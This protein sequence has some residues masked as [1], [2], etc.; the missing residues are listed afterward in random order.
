[1]E[2]IPDF[3]IYSHNLL[4]VLLFWGFAFIQFFWIFFFYIR[5]VNHKDRKNT[6]E[7]VP[8]SIIIVARNEE[9]NLFELLPS[10]LMQ[11][12]KDFEVIVVNHQSIDNTASILKAYKEKYPR[13][14][15]IN[16]ERNNHLGYGKKLPLTVGIKGAKH[17]HILLTDADCKPASSQ[18]LKIMANQFTKQKKIVLGYAP[19][20]KTQSFLNRIIRIDTTFTALNYLSFA[21]VG[22][23][24]M[25]SGKNLGYTKDLFFKNR[26]F[27]SHY[28]IPA[29]DDDLFIQEIAKKN[30]KNYTISLS[31]KA[32]CY[33]K[34]KNRWSSWISDKAINHATYS[35]YTLF[36][37][38]LLGIYPTSLILLYISLLTL[39]INNWMCWTSIII[40][41]M[42]LISKWLV[43]G[44]GFKRLD[45]KSLIWGILFFDVFYVLFMPIIYYTS[46]QSKVK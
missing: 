35:K 36:N 30:K 13:L 32:F 9:D 24:Y 27:K 23:P 28:H 43:L 18:W 42:L 16:I 1:M 26:G 6:H 45:Q 11:D 46:D 8:V 21:K 39:I 41:S 31:P 17:E 29:G 22:R 34:A 25:S 2:L 5:I 19:Y 15:V 20:L 44:F 3:S 10:V 33:S 4:F 37:K 40:V 38:V 12:Y 14:K 7:S